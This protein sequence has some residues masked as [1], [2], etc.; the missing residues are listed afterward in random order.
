MTRA[1]PVRSVD[2]GTCHVCFAFEMGFAVDLEAGAKRIASAGRSGLRPGVRN[3]AGA[4]FEQRP[5]RLMASADPMLLEGFATSAEVPVTVY[6]FGA[7]SVRFEIPIAGSAEDLVRLARVLVGNERLQEAARALAQRVTAGLGAAVDRPAVSQRS[8]DYAIY[9]LPTLQEAIVPEEG[10]PRDLLARILR[11][12]PGDLSAQE[13]E[14]A[15]RATVSYGPDD[16]AV[17]DWNA[18]VLV[19]HDPQDAIAVLE[20]ANTELSEMR[21]LDDRLD[22]ALAEA[23]SVT[24]RA[25]RGPRI[26]VVQTGRN[27]RS[28]AEMQMD[29][30]VLYESVNNALKLFGDQWLAR[31]HVTATRRLGIEEYE[32]S[33]L[34]KVQALESIYGKLRDR[35]VQLRAEILEWIIILLIAVE[36]LLYAWK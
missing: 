30:A 27:A 19:D 34:R 18:T 24:G 22:R 13:T 35:Q 5:L 29:A 7:L 36:I 10:L 31:L 33:I 16:I 3:A 11:A 1:A 20:F 32:S 23:Y 4:D 25:L 12:E 9:Q 8:E 21:Y 6:A 2:G 14:E 28:I 26:L 15:V 17:I